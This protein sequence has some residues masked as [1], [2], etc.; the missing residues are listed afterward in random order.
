[1]ARTTPAQNP[2]GEHSNTFSCGFLEVRSEIMSAPG[3]GFELSAPETR[4][5]RDLVF[6]SCPCQ[7]CASSAPESSI[8][9]QRPREANHADLLPHAAGRPEFVHIPQC[10]LGR[11]APA[12]GVAQMGAAR[13]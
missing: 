5:P 7:A 12:T 2:L 4:T 9:N 6:C 11:G 1:M 8:A 3:P 13:L 10:L